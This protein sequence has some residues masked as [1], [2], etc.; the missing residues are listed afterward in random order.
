M[1][2]TP[3]D[4]AKLFDA[5]RAVHLP[6]WPSCLFVGRKVVPPEWTERI[7]IQTSGF[8]FFSNDRATSAELNATIA[9]VT[10]RVWK[11]ATNTDIAFNYD[12]GN[13]DDS[14]R[15]RYGVLR[16]VS[17]FSNNML[18]SAC[19][20]VDSWLSWRGKIEARY[21]VGKYPSAEELYQ[22]WCVIAAA[23]PPDVLD[24]VCFV[25]DRETCQLAP[26]DQPLIQFTI[27]GGKVEVE[28]NYTRM[29]Q[30]LLS[31]HAIS[32]PA[33]SSSS[34]SFDPSSAMMSYLSL[35]AP[36]NELKVNKY[37]FPHILE[38]VARWCKLQQAII[39]EQST[40]SITS[41]TSGSVSNCSAT[42]VPPDGTSDGG[43]SNS[44]RD[45]AAPTSAPA[46]SVAIEASSTRQNRI[47]EL[48]DLDV[49]LFN[50]RLAAALMHAKG[51]EPKVTLAEIDEFAPDV[52]QYQ[53]A[54]KSPVYGRWR[55]LDFLN[56][57]QAA[58]ARV[59]NFFFTISNSISGFEFERVL[60]CELC[61]EAFTYERL[62]SDGPS[63]V[64]VRTSAVRP[65]N[66]PTND[67]S[68]E[69][70]VMADIE[71]SDASDAA[72]FGV[73]IAARP[74]T[75]SELNLPLWN[76]DAVGFYQKLPLIQRERLLKFHFS[77]L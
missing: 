51:S 77:R 38:R 5:V 9:D 61:E 59:Y 27:Q 57:E 65:R 30:D 34:S 41:S 67:L 71:A 56:A 13:K 2:D 48:D 24:L 7:A 33:V 69:K 22:E 40:S 3:L 28:T 62:T 35:F 47:A 4:I 44:N 19:V 21:N 10:S 54:Q 49:T 11:T 58:A 29:D 60:F 25:Y 23:Y 26:G 18:M 76:E 14:T 63:S 16:G 36:G 31:R 37:D 70:S 20:N 42:G 15:S 39:T 17:Y 64:T 43:P 6:K 50:V 55:N 45:V 12:D 68:S 8:D 52:A 75:A 66:T 53:Q 73:D 32:T 74:L 72:S 46:A 1:S